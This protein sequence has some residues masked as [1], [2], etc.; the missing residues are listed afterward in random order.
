MFAGLS[1]RERQE[2]EMKQQLDI[3]H[4]SCVLC[5]AYW[6]LHKAPS[7]SV[8][9]WKREHNAASKGQGVLRGRGMVCWSPT[10]DRVILSFRPLCI[11][12]NRSAEHILYRKLAQPWILMLLPLLQ[13]FVCQQTRFWRSLTYQERNWEQNNLAPQLSGVSRSL[14]SCRATWSSGVALHNLDLAYQLPKLMWRPHLPLRSF[15]AIVIFSAL[16]L[17]G[18]QNYTFSLFVAREITLNKTLEMLGPLYCCVAS[19]TATTWPFASCLVHVMY[20]QPVLPQPCFVPIDIFL[21]SNSPLMA[22][23][24][25]QLRFPLPDTPVISLFCSFLSP[26]PRGSI[27]ARRRW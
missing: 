18:V 8:W 25:W 14:S 5:S 19:S 6:S 23:W 21:L 7:P 1:E 15:K 13:H 27:E 9:W 17:L 16:E 3:S 2:R 12:V 26:V 22:V 24:C 4:G 20:N 10:A 11:Q